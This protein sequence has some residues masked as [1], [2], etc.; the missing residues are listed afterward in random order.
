M[1]LL[2]SFFF[3]LTIG[4]AQISACSSFAMSEEEKFIQGAWRAGG[5]LKNK[6][7]GPGMSWF[8]EWTFDKGKFKQTGYPPLSQEGKYRIIRKDG[9]KLTLELYDQKGTFGTENKTIEI[10][11]DK[12]KDQLKI[13]NQE[14]FKRT[15]KE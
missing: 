1:K 2:F 14:G 10:V 7:G 8:I 12:E 3:V 11:I 6:D 13:S 4:L 5:E 15:K 9:N